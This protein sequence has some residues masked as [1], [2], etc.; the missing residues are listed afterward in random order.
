[1]HP[2]VYR[3]HPFA[4]FFEKEHLKMKKAFTIVELAIV[5]VVIGII[6]GMAVKGK[7]LVDAARMKAEVAKINKFE[8]AVAIYFT[9]N[10]HNMPD[11][12]PVWPAGVGRNSFMDLGLLTNADFE[13]KV[14]NCDWGVFRC[15]VGPDDNRAF[16]SS[17][18]WDSLYASSAV[19][20]CISTVVNSSVTDAS[21]DR[22]P[23]SRRFVCNVE[24]MKDDENVT[25]GSDRGWG[26]PLTDDNRNN[27]RNCDNW[28]S[29]TWAYA[30]MVM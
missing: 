12:L 17:G 26:D 22:V 3:V 29:E 27:Y 2:F 1:V 30:F 10:E 6:L 5:L 21:W 13:Q 23:M 11:I 16:K 25:A 8:A 28:T 15:Y 20:F 9:H 24:V 4:I 18:A 7:A 14:D 19:N